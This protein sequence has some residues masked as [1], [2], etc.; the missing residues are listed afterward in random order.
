MSTA[1]AFL[2]YSSSH[3]S[4]SFS[5]TASS[6]ALQF[7]TILPAIH[8]VVTFGCCPGMVQCPSSCVKTSTTKSAA[9]VAAVQQ[10]QWPVYGGYGVLIGVLAPPSE[11]MLQPAQMASDFRRI[12]AAACTTHQ[13]S[14]SMFVG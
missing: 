5:S 2:P 7:C 8:L 9:G 4:V 13:S 1:H 6:C 14:Y 12:Y 3:R 10:S 11:I